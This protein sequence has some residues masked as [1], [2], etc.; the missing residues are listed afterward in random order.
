MP[1]G[2]PRLWAWRKRSPIIERCSRRCAPTS[3][4]SSPNVTH[5]PY[6]REAAAGGVKST[7]SSSKSPPSSGPA[8]L[9]AARPTPPRRGRESMEYLHAGARRRAAA[10]ERNCSTPRTS[11]TSTAYSP[12]SSCF[13]RPNG[14]ARGASSQLPRRMR[15]PGFACPG[16]RHAGALRRRGV[17]QQGL[18]SAWSVPV[19]EAGRGP[20]A[21]KGGRSWAAAVSAVA[22]GALK[23]RHPRQESILRHAKR[24][25]LRVN[26]CQL[27]DRTIAEV[28]GYDLSISGTCNELSIVADIRVFDVRINPADEHELF[29]PRAEAA[30]N[31]L[32]REKL[33]TPAGTSFP[34]PLQARA[35]GYANEALDAVACAENAGFVVPSRG[36]SWRGIR[37]R[38]S[39]PGTS[40][41]NVT[42][43]LCRSKSTPGGR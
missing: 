6:G 4:S 33:P 39:W 28:L 13:A 17:V 40:R 23:H 2:L 19:S 30:G 35:H 3:I 37:W 43:R 12:S 25:G 41:P 27:D 20:A 38:C 18:P 24:R 16:L 29:L 11:S 7:S 21:S 31:L 5:G 22:L 42:G 14:Q 26:H 32:L 8:I 15:P 1:T 9:P 10:G 36:R 34:R